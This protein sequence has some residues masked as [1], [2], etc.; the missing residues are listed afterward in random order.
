[1]LQQRLQHILSG[2]KSRSDEAKAK[3]AQD[4]QHFVTTELRE[5]TAEQCP[6]LMDD[7][8]HGIFVLVQ[9]SDSND[10]KGGILAIGIAAPIFTSMCF[11][12]P[13]TVPDHHHHQFKVCYYWYARNPTH[14]E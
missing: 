12:V 9:S 5:A 10:K 1:M 11:P 8:I 3:N 13:C 14:Q 2:L 7:L 4:L 6:L